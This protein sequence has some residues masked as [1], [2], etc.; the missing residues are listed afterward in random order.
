ML[1][2]RGDNI[3]EITDE[4]V[5]D[6]GGL[7]EL[8]TSSSFTPEQEG[9][10][11]PRSWIRRVAAASLIASALVAILVVSGRDAPLP[12][13]EEDR[14]RQRAARPNAARAAQ[15]PASSPPIDGNRVRV[16]DPRQER[17][18]RQPESASRP[19]DLRPIVRHG[20]AT[21]VVVA[22]PRTPVAVGAPQPLPAPPAPFEEFGFER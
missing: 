7:T 6:D 3:F 12:N 19:A 5:G 20:R 22:V 13:R 18:R 1:S 16:A 8:E 4:M 21:A 11:P 14:M 2:G 10:L 15:R 9:S 17:T